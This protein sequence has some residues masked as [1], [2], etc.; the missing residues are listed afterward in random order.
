LVAMM[1]PK[2]MKRSRSVTLFHARFKADAISPCA[3][4]AEADPM[5]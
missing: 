5:E 3:T 4:S 1:V 2:L